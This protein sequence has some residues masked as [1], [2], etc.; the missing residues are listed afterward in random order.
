MHMPGAW[1]QQ[2][3]AMDYLMYAYLQRAD[4]LKARGVLDELNK[5]SRTTPESVAPAYAFV[6]IPA[7]Y[8]I[9]RRQW[10]ER[11]RWKSDRRVFPGIV[12]RGPGRLCLSRAALGPHEKAMRLRLAMR[13]RNSQRSRRTLPT[14]EVTT[15][16]GRLKCSD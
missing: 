5:I 10:A 9:E 12:I 13:R 8:A 3:H 6:A 11:R 1:D 14:P 7:R 4:D 16:P 2:L 15:G